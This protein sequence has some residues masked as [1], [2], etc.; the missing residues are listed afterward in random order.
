MEKQTLFEHGEI[1]RIC[2]RK[3]DYEQGEFELGVASGNMLAA[4]ERDTQRVHLIPIA[5]VEEIVVEYG[6]TEAAV[7][8]TDRA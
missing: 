3:R 2:T 8:D 7:Q 5:A 6:N 4:V 1:K